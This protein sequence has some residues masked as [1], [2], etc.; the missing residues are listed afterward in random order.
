MHTEKSITWPGLANLFIVYIV[1]GSTYLAIRVAVRDGAG[2][3]PFML[4]ALRVVIAGLLLLAWGALRHQR[5]KPTRQEWVTLLISGL[6]L[7][8]GGNGLVNWAE[9]RVDSSLAALIISATPIWVALVEAIIDR[10]WPSPRLV[11]ALLVGFAG[12]AVLTYPTLRSGVQADLWSVIGLLAAGLSWGTGSVYQ[13]R[14]PVQLAPRVNA[15]YQHLFGAAGFVV[16]VLVLG[17]PLPTPAADAWLAF[18]YLVVFGSLL[19]FT[20]YVTALQQL[21]TKIVVTYAYVNPVIAV[22]LGWAILHEAV[23]AY[24]LAGAA[25]VLL[26][27]GGVFRERYRG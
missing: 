19:A 13:S 12:I 21:P 23:S 10:R 18:V 8:V 5:I 11:A 3:T 6:L 1:W 25:L 17:E 9:R 2:F 15:G 24:T 20:A 4:G 26:G 7:W 22:F 14:K 16:L 27:V